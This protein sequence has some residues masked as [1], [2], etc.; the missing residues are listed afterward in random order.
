[1]R[2]V[3]YDTRRAQPNFTNVILYREESY[4]PEQGY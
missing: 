3:A 2:Q 1:M 4:S